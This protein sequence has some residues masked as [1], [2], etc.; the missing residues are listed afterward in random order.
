MV[1][2]WLV[3]ERLEVRHHS[4]SCAVR[5]SA[6]SCYVF[7][8]IRGSLLRSPLLLLIQPLLY[9]D[10]S[11]RHQQSLDA[12]HICALQSPGNN[13]RAARF[14]I[15]GVKL[16]PTNFCNLLFLNHALKVMFLGL[17]NVNEQTSMNRMSFSAN[18]SLESAGVGQNHGLR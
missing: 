16:W 10:A 8:I 12:G 9:A 3:S 18:H 5:A 4:A 6:S 14:A 11:P 17:K 1:T 13:Q 7:M 2:R 15:R